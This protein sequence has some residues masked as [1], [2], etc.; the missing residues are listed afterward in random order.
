MNE[1]FRRTWRT[2]LAGQTPGVRTQT[3][4]A[5]AHF[6]FADPPTVPKSFFHDHKDLFKEYRSD[7]STARKV[8]LVTSRIQR[9]NSEVLYH[10][11]LVVTTAV[12]RLLI[13]DVQSRDLD[14][15]VADI[16]DKDVN[17]NFIKIHLFSHFGY[18]IQHF[19]NIGIILPYR[20]RQITNQLSREAIGSQIKVMQAIKYQ[21]CM[22]D[23]TGSKFMK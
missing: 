9:E 14:V 19:G 18:H 4:F 6:S 15:M 23:L 3:R 22:L 7:R 12:Q 13:A 20:G 17:F 2:E 11:D 8:K 1:Q 5:N 21:E 10:N 16:Y